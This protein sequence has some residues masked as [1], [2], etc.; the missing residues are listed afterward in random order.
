[1]NVPDALK[2]QRA[3]EIMAIQAEISNEL[4]REKVGKIF[5]ILVDRE[6][7]DYYI[8]RT[9]FDSP[10]VDDEVL[11]AKNGKKLTIGNFY[12]VKIVSSS[13]FELTGELAF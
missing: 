6:V 11:I 4:N 2:Q 8:G 3:D 1:D 10:E 7:D 13:D 9:E 5:K 12:P